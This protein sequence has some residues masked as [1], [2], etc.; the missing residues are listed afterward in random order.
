MR[1]VQV[2]KIGGD[3]H[4]QRIS[5]VHRAESSLFSRYLT[6]FICRHFYIHMVILR[7]KWRIQFRPFVLWDLHKLAWTSIPKRQWELLQLTIT[8]PISPPTSFC[9]HFFLYIPTCIIHAPTWNQTLHLKCKIPLCCSRKFPNSSLTHQFMESFSSAYNYATIFFHPK[10][11]HSL[12]STSLTEYFLCS[13][14]EKSF[15]SCLP[16]KSPVL[17]L[18]FLKYT[19]TRLLPS[20]HY[21]N[22]SCYKQSHQWQP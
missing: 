4:I 22:Y 2:C 19:P 14:A 15:K 20:L 3:T 13:S 1:F 11:N 18:P 16:L 10:K 7:L 6:I 8:I 21:K 17:L 12:V 9:I 5:I